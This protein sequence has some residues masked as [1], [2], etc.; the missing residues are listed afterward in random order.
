LSHN[1][2][3]AYPLS[4]NHIDWSLYYPNIAPEARLVR[5]L[6]IG[7][8]F[9]GLTVALSQLFPEKL[10]LGVEIRAKVCEYVRLRINAL[11]AETEGKQYENASCIRTNCM[12]YMANY[13]AKGQLEKIFICFPDPHFKVKNFRRRI[14]SHILLSEYAYFLQPG[15][16]LYTVTGN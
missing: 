13:F 10:V 6:D 12:R 1:D 2:G 3:F 8:G 16:K 7:M 4:S 5:H 11:R 14:V 9:G 15:G